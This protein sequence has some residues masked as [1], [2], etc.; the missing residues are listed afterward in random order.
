VRP[1]T[2]RAKE[3]LFNILT[4]QLDF[5]NLHALE[6]F[7]GTGNLSYELA[8]RGANSIL[9]IDIDRNCCKFIQ[10][11]A[12]KFG[13]ATLKTQQAD[14]LKFIPKHTP[15]APYDLIIADP[16]YNLAELRTLPALVFDHQLLAPQGI[17]I[18]EHAAMQNISQHPN[19]TENRQYGQSVFSFFVNP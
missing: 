15:T 2:D 3:A 7:A 6:L 13:F 19:F 12:E 16:P 14:V 9:A 1:T 5:E 8:S 18:I 11:T 4:H 10:Q 17:L